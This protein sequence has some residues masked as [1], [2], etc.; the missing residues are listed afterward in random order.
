MVG[1]R[2]PP[3]HTRATVAVTVI[4][5]FFEYV[6]KSATHSVYQIIALF[7]PYFIY[8]RHSDTSVMLTESSAILSKRTHKS[9]TEA[10]GTNV[11]P[12]STI[13]VNYVMILQ[14]QS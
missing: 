9:R 7:V 8:C 4:N 3:S 10:I 11:H 2:V 6:Y 13:T 5:C 12:V 14:L 1:V